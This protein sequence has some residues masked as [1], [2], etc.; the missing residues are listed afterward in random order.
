MRGRQWYR[1]F[2]YAQPRVRQHYL[3]LIQELLDRYDC[4]GIELDW[5][6]FPWHFR[7][8]KEDDG[9][10]HLNDFMQEVRRL[11]DE[12]TSRRGHPVRIAARIPA[13]PEFA[14]G[15]GM[16]GATWAREGWIDMLIVSPEWRPSDTDIPIERWRELLG[17][18]NKRILL[19]AA[20]D[21][22]L[23]GMPGG[24]VM[25]DDLRTQRAFTAAMLC[26]GADG[27]Y[28]FNHFNWNDFRRSERTADGRLVV[29]DETLALLRTA[30][31]L[32]AALRGPRRHVVTFHHPAAPNRP[33]PKPLPAVVGRDRDATF[34]IY[35]GPRP[36]TGRVTLRVGLQERPGIDYARLLARLNGAP[37]QPIAD[38]TNPVPRGSN[39][40]DRSRVFHVADTAD[41]MLQFEAPLAALRHGS[42]VIEISVTQSEPQK[43][44]WLEVYVVPARRA[45]H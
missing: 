35:T 7:P 24:K 14:F 3:A 13:V 20:T 17:P 4:D 1:G 16:D 21:L 38:L 26:R 28:L 25:S 36:S 44:V 6:R 42:N 45:P 27:I 40:Q 39:P 15:L 43:I 33:N 32:E 23:Q 12:A 29:R 10:R 31:R 9:R 41:R 37:C 34:S 2:D 19:I 5:M 30:G 18:A 11:A 22:W 8:G